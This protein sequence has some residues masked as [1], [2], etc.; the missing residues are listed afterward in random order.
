MCSAPASTSRRTRSRCAP[1]WSTSSRATTRSTR[2]GWSSCATPAT[3]Y[4]AASPSWPHGRTATTTSTPPATPASDSCSRAPIATLDALQAVSILAPGPFA[5]LRSDL[6]EIRSLFEIDEQ[7]LKS[8]VILPGQNPPRPIDGPSAAAR[9]E[10]CERRAHA[11]VASWTDTLVD[12]LNEKE[13]AEQVGYVSDA[14]ARGKIETLAKT[15]TLPDPIDGPFIEALNQVF[16]RVDIRNVSPK[17]LNDALFPDTSPATG[18]QLRERLESL[19]DK[20]T[21]GADPERV[22]FLPKGDDES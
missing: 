18:D 12:S 8:S 21:A 17:E 11:L 13:M 5:Q 20:L 19:L 4:A 14:T 2:P 6:V 3:T 15:R 10:E 1:T 9:L 22:R 16:N 7:A